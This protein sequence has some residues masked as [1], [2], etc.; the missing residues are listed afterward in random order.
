MTFERQSELAA[1]MRDPMPVHM[2][3][4]DVEAQPWERIAKRYSD[5][6]WKKP[7]LDIVNGITA[8]WFRDQLFAT[9]AMHTL[10]IAQTPTFDIHG[11]DVLKIDISHKTGELVFIAGKYH[12]SV[13]VTEGVKTLAYIL[14]KRL[15]WIPT[16]EHFSD[17]SLTS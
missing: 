12:K 4:R 6:Q 10:I 11:A 1:I 16:A 17:S 7:M 3:H 14:C 15:K 2:T 8:S 5:A 13:K 9:T